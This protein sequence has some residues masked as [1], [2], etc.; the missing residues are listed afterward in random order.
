MNNPFDS[1][2]WQ[3]VEVKKV[4]LEMNFSEQEIH[5]LNKR[6]IIVFCYVTRISS[7][8]KQWPQSKNIETLS[9]MLKANKVTSFRTK[10]EF[11]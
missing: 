2:S 8:S 6:T 9:G 7:I 4:Q 11:S 3:N 5:G 10:K 1:S